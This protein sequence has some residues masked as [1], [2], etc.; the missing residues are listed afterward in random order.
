[1]YL[2]V[3]SLIEFIVFIIINNEQLFVNYFVFIL[4]LTPYVSF[5]LIWLI[6]FNVIIMF[7]VKQ[8]I[9]SIVFVQIIFELIHLE[10]ITNFKLILLIYFKSINLIIKPPRYFDFI[11][12]II[13]YMYFIVV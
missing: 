5:S 8:L 9:I 4:K 2:L 6:N 1:M 12:I 13:N 10:F 3:I 11:T 7:Y